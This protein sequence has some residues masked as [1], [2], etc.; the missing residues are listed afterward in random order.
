MTNMP[1]F[2]R[3]PRSRKIV[4]FI[5]TLFLFA[6]S[7][8]GIEIIL[9]TT[10]LFGARISWSEPDPLLFYRNI[11]EA[12]YWYFKENDHP[13]KGK[14]NAYGWRDKEWSIKKPLNTYRIAV[15]GDSFVESLQVEADR[16]FLSLAEKQLR[17]NSRMKVELMNFG[18]SGFTQTE[19]LLILKNQILQFS[20]DMVILFFFPGND[21]EEVSRE[22]TSDFTHPFYNLSNDGELMLDAHFTEG[23]DFKIRSFMNYFK[24]HSALISLIFER[25]I[26]FKGSLAKSEDRK[27]LPEYLTLCTAKPK[28]SY[29]NSYNMTKIL[30]KK[31][32][33]ICKQEKIRFM[34]VTIDNPAYLSE[35]RGEYTRMDPSFNANYIDDDLANYAGWLS[36]EYL[37]LQRIFSDFNKNTGLFLHWHKNKGHWNYQGHEV[38]AN[39]L[40]DK[41]KQ[42]INLRN[43]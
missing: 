7:M 18:R 15:L 5:F 17:Q 26:A 29:I 3:D 30:I 34:L 40:S 43:E 28:M 33:E 24:R 36:I 39:A 1:G 22:T 12:E 19:E 4:Y 6:C 42:I 16:N 2:Q 32:A 25:Y 13:I 10:H 23:F 41:L 21:I 31:I 35:T 27:N 9:R 14:F 37:G 11:P 8:V 38:V 20:P